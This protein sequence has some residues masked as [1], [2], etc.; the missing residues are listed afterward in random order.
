MTAYPFHRRQRARWTYR[1]A[2]TAL[3]AGLVTYLAFGC[4]S[5]QESP[6]GTAA[7][8][9]ESQWNDAEARIITVSAHGIKGDGV[10]DNAEALI[11]LRDK[12]IAEDRAAHWHII[13]PPGHYLTTNNRWIY[14]LLRVRL[15]GY[16]AKLQNISTLRYVNDYNPFPRQGMFS[17]MGDIASS[18]PPNGERTE[19]FVSGDEIETAAAGSQNIVLASPEPQEVYRAGDRVLIHGYAMQN[20]GYSP[21]LRYFEWHRIASVS[22]RTVRLEKPLEYRYNRDW[23]DFLYDTSGTRA[24]FTSPAVSFGKPRVL[25]LDDRRQVVGRYFYPEIVIIEGFEF[26]PN[27]YAKTTKKIAVPARYVLLKDLVLSGDESYSIGVRESQLTVIDACDIAN[28]IEF[29]KVAV[30][31]VVTG[32]RIR[33]MQTKQPHALK[34][35][36]GVEEIEIHG[37]TIDGRVNVVALKR[38]RVTGNRI[39]ARHLPNSPQWGAVSFYNGQFGGDFAEVTGNSFALRSRQTERIERMDRQAYVVERPPGDGGLLVPR[40]R[41]GHGRDTAVPPVIRSLRPGLRV[42]LKHDRTISARVADTVD[43][44][45]GVFKVLFDDPGFAGTLKVGDVIEWPTMQ[46]VSFNDNVIER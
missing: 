33:R 44:P 13:F 45:A 42:A 8:Q 27:P 4:A 17:R 11:K 36:T 37:N 46:A 20:S 3:V 25:L 21:N 32:S 31:A 9:V 6:V 7:A 23:P 19:M 35:G 34:S 15:S 29:D 39:D 43:G 22:G 16:G 30:K 1:N 5:A 12:L 10:T 28:V 38:L 2:A 26:L 14:G 18:G 24:G 41:D 40:I